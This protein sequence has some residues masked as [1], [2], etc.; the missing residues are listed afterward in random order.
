MILGTSRQCLCYL[1]CQKKTW[2][3]KKKRKE[4]DVDFTVHLVT[5]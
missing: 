4:K 1:C 3:L 5:G 2:V